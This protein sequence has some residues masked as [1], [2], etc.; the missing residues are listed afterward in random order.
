MVCHDFSK[1]LWNVDQRLTHAFRGSS[2]TCSVLL[3]KSSVHETFP[4]YL[5]SLFSRPVSAYRTAVTLQRETATLHF[6]LPALTF[7]KG[8]PRD[9]WWEVRPN[10]IPN[11]CVAF[12]TFHNEFMHIHLFNPSVVWSQ[13]RLA[14]LFSLEEW[15]SQGILR[16]CHLNKV[17]E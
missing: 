9:Y 6:L 4:W 16:L 8:C 12:Y 2:V 3:T 7:S 15:G 10:V 5:T 1:L 13:A 17:T 11:I 14:L